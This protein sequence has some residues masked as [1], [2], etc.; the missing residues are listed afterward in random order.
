MKKSLLVIALMVLSVGMVLGVTDIQLRVHQG[1]GIMDFTEQTIGPY[2]YD[3]A[4]NPHVQPTAM[5]TEHIV[6]HGG[7]DIQKRITSFGTGDAW[8]NR[9][10]KA[11]GYGD[12]GELYGEWSLFE[13]KQVLA[14][15]ETWKNKWVE[16]WTVHP[17]WWTT[18]EI[19][20]DDDTT[21]QDTYVDIKG[22]NMGSTTQ[23]VKHVYTNE[24]LNELEM[25]WINPWNDNMDPWDDEE[26]EEC[27]EFPEIPEKPSMEFCEDHQCQ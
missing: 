15:G 23:F 24:P 4:S 8:P 13:S 5:I 2:G 21:T 14:T 7:I 22:T 6:N 18:Y 26:G 16:I 3:D 9:N 1:N 11:Q 25:V 17:T 20:E 10:S 27:F 12:N 19:L